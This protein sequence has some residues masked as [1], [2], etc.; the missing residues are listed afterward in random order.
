MREGE[1]TVTLTDSSQAGREGDGAGAE[2]RRRAL[3][4]LGRRRRLLMAVAVAAL[5]ATAVF[6]V[7]VVL[8]N[9]EEA[10]EAGGRVNTA[11]VVVK[12]L[13]DET[14]YDATLGRPVAGELTAGIAGTVTW[15]PEAGAVISSGEPLFA[16]DD[17][18]VLLVEGQVPAF[19][20][21]RLGKDEISLPAGGAG[22]LTWLPAVGSILRSGDVVAKVDDEP[23]V[24]LDGSLPMY[25][26][27]REGVEGEDVLQLESALAALGYDP[28]GA[29]TVDEEFTSATAG[30]V[31]RWQEALGVA[32][33]GRVS[34]GDIVFAPAPAQV[35][36]HDAAVGSSVGPSAPILHVSGGEPLSGPDVRQLEEAL[37]D[38]GR[39]PGSVDG[40]YDVDTASAVADWVDDVGHGADGLLAVGSIVFS[41]GDLRATEVLAD[42]GAAVSP[43]T[44]VIS[45]ADVQTIVRLDLPAEDQG[46]LAVG[47]PV[48]IVMPDRSEAAGAVT[49]VASVAEGGGPGE[50][51]TFDV[52]IALG[53]PSA[54]E[55]LDE[56]PVDVRVVSEVVEDATAV[57]VSAL[58]ALAEGGYAV[59]VV[60]GETTRLTAVDPG[61]FADGWVEITGDVQ[62][63][64]VVVV[65]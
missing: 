15:A 42:V 11:E 27:L 49:F 57:P 35:I 33:T 23:V 39:D 62:P 43:A 65:P 50:E 61:F 22:T 2:G 17:R 56:A 14:I 7:A 52:E 20:G 8:G 60:E 4:L 30:M 10:D 47:D 28:D 31:E 38:L 16:I 32:E 59:E 37:A 18:P 45:A 21:F 36:A 1:V 55:G 46:L 54:A 48:V 29:V 53:D 40:A 5:A 19:R 13:A 9:G 34:V 63:G 41:L 24:L 26:V 64:D 44:P 3:G 12:D 6:V 51:A 58:L 25:R